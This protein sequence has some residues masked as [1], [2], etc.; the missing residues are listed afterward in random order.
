MI[1]IALSDDQRIYSTVGKAAKAQAHTRC[2]LPSDAICLLIVLL[3]P[4]F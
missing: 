4:T 2:F 1:G 3:L